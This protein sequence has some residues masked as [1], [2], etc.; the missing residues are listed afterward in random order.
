MI[1]TVLKT[2][3]KKAKPKEI[4]YRCYKNFVEN[5]FR[6]DFKKKILTEDCKNYGKFEEMFLDCLNHHAPLKKRVVRP[7]EVPY[8]SKH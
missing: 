5:K 1:L 4:T 6:S 3:F 8:T 2:T 7:N